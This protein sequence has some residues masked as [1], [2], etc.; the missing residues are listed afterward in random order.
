MRSL[1]ALALVLA[2]AP[3]LAAPPKVMTDIPAV[4]ALTASVMGDLGTPG[5]LLDQGADAHHFQLRPSQAKALSEADLLLWIGPRMTPWLERA[6]AGVGLA[7]ESV[8]LIEAPGTFRRDFDEAA[9]KD[10]HADEDDHAEAHDHVEE[11]HAHGQED[12]AGADDHDH[13]HAKTG[14]DPHAWLDPENARVWTR[15]IAD[16]LAAL[17]P[18][19]GAAYAANAAATLAAIDAAE[20]ETRALLAPVDDAAIMVFHDAYGYFADHFGVNVAGAIALGD[21][22]DPGAGRLDAL[23][24][25]LRHEGVACIFP[26]AQHDPAYVA[27]IVEGTG[28]RVGAPLDPSGSTLAYGPDLYPA[29][30]TGLARSIAD[31]VTGAGG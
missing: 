22:A 12:H 6:V 18:G 28:T 29:L 30:L 23:R 24:D 10:G 7:G 14:L 31:C 19:N 3:A 9:G 21:A 20:A 4:H 2:A 27:A 16:R 26:E 8:I 11:D 5:I 15:L 1:T 13:G 17:D 25:E